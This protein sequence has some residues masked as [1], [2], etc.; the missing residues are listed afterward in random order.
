ME[1]STFE[2]NVMQISKKPQGRTVEIDPEYV[3]MIEEIWLRLEASRYEDDLD[4]RF[5]A[6]VQFSIKKQY[7]LT[8]RYEL[9]KQQRLV[10][11]MQGDNSHTLK[12]LKRMIEK[13]E[14]EAKKKED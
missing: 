9:R 7:G 10:G 8:S 6:A 14:R 5:K 1:N 4:K 3:R 11:D 13:L 12:D 2:D